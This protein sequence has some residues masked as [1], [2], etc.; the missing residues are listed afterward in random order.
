MK[1]K[2]N[3]LLLGVLV[4]MELVSACLAWRDLA[5]RGNDGVRGNK[6]TWRVLIVVNPGNSV[7]YWVFGRR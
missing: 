2:P 6:N 7:F 5:H 1:P 3:R 4:G